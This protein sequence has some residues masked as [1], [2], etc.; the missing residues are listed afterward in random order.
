MQKVYQRI[1]WEN[2]PSQETPLNETNLN[3]IDYAVDEHDNR[4][5]SLDSTKL[6]K[7]TANGLVNA[8]TFNE[9]TGVL[10]ISYL[11]GATATIDTK[12]EKIAVNFKYDTETQKLIIILDDGTTQEVDLS[13]LISQYEFLESDSIAFELTDGK[14]KA[15]VKNGSITEDKL[16]P[17][18]LADIKVEQEKARSSANA[19]A[20]SE[21]NADKYQS[22]AEQYMNDTKK[23]AGDQ[24]EILEEINRKLQMT[25]FDIDS[26]GNLTYTDETSYTFLVDDNGDM[27]WEVA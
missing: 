1:N 16:Q 15:V 25:D 26:D 20:V 6:D 3:I 23:I 5:I 4:I 10:T 21:D 27:N 17:N 18:Y 22:M 8:I 12:L 13:T 2:Y 19:A 24:G 7:I 9:S 11:S 14:V